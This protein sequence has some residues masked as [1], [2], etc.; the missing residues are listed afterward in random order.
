MLIKD[1]S[2]QKRK[3][4]LGLA[5]KRAKPGSGSSLTF[6]QKRTWSYPVNSLQSVLKS[7]PFVV[8]GGVAT[9][10]YMP[11]RMTLDIDILIKANDK[12]LIYQDLINAQ[13]KKIGEL[14]IAGSQWQ[15]S[16]NTALDV[17]EAED[18]WVD[19]A[20]SK[21]NYSPD[22]IPVIA[23][24]YLVLMKLS[25]SRTQ[26]LADVSRMLGLAS[27]KDLSEVRQV[28]ALYLPTATEDLDSL[29]ALGKLEISI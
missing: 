24:P 6:L 29:I 14:S 28:I 11:E 1:L 12:N 19:A 15:L 5:I 4:F 23:L 17:L 10:L 2:A 3:F 27:E 18:D 9:R 26:D 16:D 7:A 22:K 8:V 25:A 20:L 13:A 21:P